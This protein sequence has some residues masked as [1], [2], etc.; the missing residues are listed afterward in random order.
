MKP[1]FVTADDFLDYWGINLNA[2]L[3]TNDNDSNKADTYLARVELRLMSW[4]DKNSFRVTPWNNLAPFQIQNFR[5][6]IL[7]QAMY[8]WRNGDIEMDSGYDQERGVVLHS[9]DKED[10]VICKSCLNFLFTAGLFN[11]KITNRKR[12][13][14]GDSFGVFEKRP[15]E[16]NG[17]VG[18]DSVPQD[19]FRPLN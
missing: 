4:I 17:V 7:E 5:Y 13:M 9:N 14:G 19:P 16:I 18:D 15:K 11:L 1:L 8:M 12:Y 10:I 2:R 3:R 6:A